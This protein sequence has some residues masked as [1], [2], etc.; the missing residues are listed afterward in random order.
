M[1]DY[2]DIT[3]ETQGV[4]IEN[5]NLSSSYPKCTFTVG[6]DN[7]KTLEEAGLHPQAVLF[8]QNLDS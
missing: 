5:Y 3:F 6:D 1:R 2:I 4:E 8:V 7:L